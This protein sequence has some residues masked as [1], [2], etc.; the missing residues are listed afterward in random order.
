MTDAS[1]ESATVEA[2]ITCK[3]DGALTHSIQKHLKDKY[4]DWTLERYMK[5]YPGEPIMSEYAKKILQDRQKQRETQTALTTALPAGA[6]VEQKPMAEIFELGAVKGALNARGQPIMVSTFKKLGLEDSI[7]IPEIDPDFVFDLDKLR[8]LLIGFEMN[9]PMLIWGYHGTGKT[10]LAEQIA[11]RTGRPFV[12]VQHT[13]N[14]EEAHVVGQYV[15]K[16]GATIWQ[17]GPLSIAMR[18]GYT[19][20]ADEYD[21]AQPNVIAVYQPVLEGKPMLIKEAPP[22]LRMVKPHPNFRFV[23]T[24]NTNG[25]GDETGLYQGT[26]LQNAANYSR[27]GITL[28]ISY[29]DPKI[30]KAILSAK[31]RVDA[32]T[33]SKFVDFA[34][35][36]RKAFMGSK[37]SMTISPRELITAAKIGRIRGGD[38]KA[39]LE[40][41]FMNRLTRADKQAIGEYA[42]R[43]FG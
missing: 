30:E 43:V 32:E 10:S 15:V 16:D 36:V 26:M 29:L 21:F 41:G 28:E 7:W 40:V 20:C 11:A 34:D 6:E 38:W 4:P 1:A 3:I 18:N 17:D 2:K 25:A 42:Q 37:V 31:S 9:I 33:A 39:G 22:E 8:T 12:R 5:E 14:T 19:Y 35:S 24:G 27:F 13:A 23:A